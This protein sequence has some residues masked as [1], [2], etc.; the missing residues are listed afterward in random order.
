MLNTT[1]F[2]KIATRLKSAEDNL[3]TEEAVKHS[4]I[5]PFISTMGYDVFNPNE[6]VPEYNAD[7]G[8]KTGEKVD[9][10]IMINRQPLMMI[11][12]K[13]LQDPL[14]GRRAS[15]LARYYN[16]TTC[17]VGILTNGVCWKFFCDL[18]QTNVMDQEPF[19]EVDL[20]QMNEAD[21]NKLDNFT[22]ENFELERVYSTAANLKYIAGIKRYLQTLLHEPDEEFI[23][24][25]VKRVHTGRLLQKDVP[26]FKT[27]VRN[28]LRSFTSDVIS[29]SLQSAN[30]VQQELQQELVTGDPQ[31]KTKEVQTTVEE[32]AAYELIKTMLEDVIDPERILM[33][34]T[35]EYCSI[36][37]D[38]RLQPVVRL[39]FDSSPKTIA[40][41]SKRRTNSNTRYGER[42][43][44]NEISDI[45]DH[46]DTIIDFLVTE[47][48]VEV[49]NVVDETTIEEDTELSDTEEPE[50]I[51]PEE[52]ETPRLSVFGRFF[53]R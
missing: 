38:N 32:V 24:F 36:N 42:I 37:L 31:K 22:K 16:V 51:E 43:P 44:I 35:L 45:L 23:R 49:P 21:I 27:L 6:V 20:G 52:E 41:P 11:E 4:L 15:Q 18:E 28:A 39:R 25:I 2:E 26:M 7:F 12:C 48:G 19:L 29:Q 33:K 8:I 5:L 47:Y 1:S 40:I 30:K 34:D 53:R 17:K 3:L 14:D 10:A 50:P 46:K 9:Y 13:K